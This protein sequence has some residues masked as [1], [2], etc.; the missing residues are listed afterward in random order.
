VLCVRGAD[1]NDS[2]CRT[3]NGPHITSLEVGQGHHF[4]GD[5]AQ[6]VDLLLK[7]YS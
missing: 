1:E 6:L 2:A 7:T 5:Y 3:L 4:S